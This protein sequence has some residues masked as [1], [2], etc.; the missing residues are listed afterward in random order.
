MSAERTGRIA[1]RALSA[2]KAASAV[3]IL[4]ATATGGVAQAAPKPAD[5]ADV[6]VP[7]DDISQRL[8]TDAEVVDSESGTEPMTN[9]TITPAS[10]AALYA[11]GLASSYD[12][13][14]Y[15]DFVMQTVRATD[16]N[17]APNAVQV[18][19]EF[20][21][22]NAAQ[23]FVNKQAAVWQ[24]CTKLTKFAVQYADGATADF[25]SGGATLTGMELF[26]SI[27]PPDL[28]SNGGCERVMQ[29]KNNYVVDVSVCM[30]DDS[31]HSAGG[32]GRSLRSQLIRNLS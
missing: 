32:A 10:C 11:P 21:D 13:S 18:V 30:S 24:S 14:G 28:R 5:L 22:M 20:P 1:R 29:A 16:G 27:Y 8:H 9:A 4:A 17:P 6:L 25:K 23:S 3:A 7:V 15:T 26:A 19:A 12:G 31:D 2:G